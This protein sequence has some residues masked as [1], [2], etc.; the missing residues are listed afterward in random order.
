VPERPAPAA[1]LP[2]PSAEPSAEL[3]AELSAERTSPVRRKPA[4]RSARAAKAPVKRAKPR[5]R[6]GTARSSRS[7]HL[8]EAVPPQ[9]FECE[10]ERASGPVQPPGGTELV[11]TAAEILSE[12]AKAGISGGERLLKDALSR[13]SR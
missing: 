9:G 5:A 8:V 6:A 10:G 4:E 7:R 13:L 12:I 3:G 2:E 11:A 1:D